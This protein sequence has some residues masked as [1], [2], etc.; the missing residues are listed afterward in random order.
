MLVY[1]LFILSPIATTI[2]YSIYI[3]DSK[4]FSVKRLWTL[5]TLLS[6]YLGLLNTTREILS[7]NLTYKEY[8]LSVPLYDITSF[9]FEFGK[10]PLYYGYTYLSYYIL[11]GS[12]NLFVISITIINYLLLSYSII[13]IS[14]AIN[15]NMRTAITALFVMAFFFPEFA[16]SSQLIRQVL[17][18]SILL[19][20]FTSYYMYDKKRWWIA[21]CAVATHST[22]IIPIIIGT[23]PIIKNK[24][25][26]KSTLLLFICLITVAGTLFLLSS[27]FS[28][29]PFLGYISERSN[30][31]NLFETDEGQGLLNIVTISYLAIL[32][33]LILS[34]FYNIY[35]LNKKIT[36]VAMINLLLSLIVF[37]I[38]AYCINAYFLFMRYFY[39]LYAY[40][41]IITLL[42]LHNFKYTQNNLIRIFIMIT[43]VVFF[44]YSF[45]N[46]VIK[47]I[48]I[49]DAIVYP[50]P[51]Y[52]L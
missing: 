30:D 43:I 20:F 1:L 22:S 44:F 8:F 51:V 38:S 13:Y 29:V 32:L 26:I 14:K 33:F 41:G 4:E 19:T 2:G 35:I 15:A 16:A 39:Y 3:W 24:L 36:G 28:N 5:A 23:I 52:I 10:E 45:G 18:Q 9:L 48:P 49:I 25:S 17:A 12:W 7:D 42:Y 21:L 40:I 47:Y 31:A 27:S 37:I 46:N 34:L 11:G 6:I 50:A